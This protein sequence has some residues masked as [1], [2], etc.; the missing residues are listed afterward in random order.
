MHVVVQIQDITQRR[1]DETRLLMHA[2]EQEALTAVA[3]LVASEAHP[4]AVF[5]AA[6]EQVAAIP[7]RRPRQRG[8][9]G[10]GRG[11]ADGRRLDGCSPAAPADRKAAR[12]RRL[13][14]HRPRAAHRAQA[15]VGSRAVRA[16]AADGLPRAGRADRSQRQAVGSGQRRLDPAAG[17]RSRGTSAAGAV[18]SP[19]QPGRDRRR[20]ARAALH[21]WRPPTTSPASI[22]GGR[23][24]T[25]WRRRSP[26]PAATAVR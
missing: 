26:A 9:P 19:R 13:D 10:G 6:A 5:A 12:P 18:R 2:R 14:R 11:G 4:R 16:T 3:T 21:G 1:R 8:P 20:G 23:S 22:T 17:G 7:E 25:A 24:L 15:S